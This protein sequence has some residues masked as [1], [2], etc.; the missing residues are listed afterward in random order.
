MATYCYCLGHVQNVHVDQNFGHL[1]ARYGARIRALQYRYRDDDGRR[2]GGITVDDKITH[3]S[4]AS[5]FR[6]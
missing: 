4:G 5:L 3:R 1:T 6:V 2:Q